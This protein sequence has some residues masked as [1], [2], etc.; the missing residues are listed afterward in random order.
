MNIT[1]IN[2]DSLIASYVHE[3]DQ[4]GEPAVLVEF[5]MRGDHMIEDGVPASEDGTG[6]GI[7]EIGVPFSEA[8]RMLDDF[9][10]TNENLRNMVR[11]HIDG[12]NVLDIKGS[13]Y[14]SV[15]KE[16]NSIVRNKK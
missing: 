3:T 8:K 16:V 14:L 1:I 4:F 5:I 9:T 7:V 15:V 11:V 12:A 10:V 13:I 2:D 6:N